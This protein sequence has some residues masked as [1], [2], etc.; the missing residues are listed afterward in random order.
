MAKVVH[1]PRTGITAAVRLLRENFLKP[2]DPAKE[3]PI[4]TEMVEIL[5]KH[6]FDL[7]SPEKKA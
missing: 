6:G 1:T 7:D 3:D 2:S 4:V 5:R